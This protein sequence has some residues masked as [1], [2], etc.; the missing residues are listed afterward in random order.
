MNSATPRPPPT[1]PFH[2]TMSNSR[3]EPGSAGPPRRNP[4][5]RGGARYTPQRQP[6]KCLFHNNHRPQGRVRRKTPTPRP[7]QALATPTVVY[8]YRDAVGSPAKFTA[9][10]WPRK[11]HADRIRCARGRAKVPGLRPQLALAGSSST[12]ESPTSQACALEPS[13][14]RPRFAADPIAIARP[15]NGT[16]RSLPS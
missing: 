9:G 13:A 11:P 4:D 14:L 16:R 8:A 10:A 15:R 2:F 12:L 3:A 1:L 7:T 5:R 6:V